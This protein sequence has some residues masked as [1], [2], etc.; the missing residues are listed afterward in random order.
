MKNRHLKNGF[1][2]VEAFIIIVV[3]AI[4]GALGYVGY[5]QLSKNGAQEATETST[6][7]KAPEKIESTS[8]LDDTLKAVDDTSADGDTS[9]LSELDSQAAAIN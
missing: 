8:D 4:I 7:I 5:N 3:V 2:V 9:D 1:S 6:T